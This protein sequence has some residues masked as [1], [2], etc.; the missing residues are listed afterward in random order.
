MG[1]FGDFST[2]GTLRILLEDARLAA[3]EDDELRGAVLRALWSDHLSFQQLLPFLTPPKR[4]NLGGLYSSFLR[5][6]LAEHL[7]RHELLQALAWVKA[8]RNLSAPWTP[9]SECVSNLICTGL[10][11]IADPEVRKTMG[12]I[13]YARASQ[14][15]ESMCPPGTS[16]WD[17]FLRA[18]GKQRIA[19]LTRR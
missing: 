1:R 4:P 19:A 13:A 2:R 8:R 12:Q 10:E 14:R 3:D 17:K 18:W 15:E 16:K 9:E 7:P 6:E 11:N 5:D